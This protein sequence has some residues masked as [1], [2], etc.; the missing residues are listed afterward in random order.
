MPKEGDRNGPYAG[1]HLV[2]EV[3]WHRARTAHEVEQAA[4]TDENVQA[5]KSGEEKEEG[6][7]GIPCEDHAGG[8]QLNPGGHL[9][10]EKKDAQKCGVD[11]Q[12]V[13]G[14]LI[15]PHQPPASR[16]QRKAAEN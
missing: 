13:K 15:V 1:R 14:R 5:V 8:E 9:A 6:G 7:M 11:R 12:A 2:L 4:Q 16:F 10:R 3:M